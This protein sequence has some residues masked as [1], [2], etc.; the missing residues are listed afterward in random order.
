MTGPH[1]NP[2]AF[3]DDRLLAFALG[4][5]DDAELAAALD[6]APDLRERLARIADDVGRISDSL[7]ATVPPAAAGYAEPSR[8]RWP[9]LA[10]FF[11]PAD[12]TAAG[13]RRRF[14]R[15]VTPAVAAALV[16]AVVVAALIAVRPGPQGGGPNDYAAAPQSRGLSADK[17]AEQASPGGG[18][19][20]ATLGG[21]KKGSLVAGAGPWRSIL[22]ARAGAVADGVQRFAVVRKLKGDVATGVVR[23]HLTEKIRALRAG[24]LWVLYLEPRDQD[25]DGKWRDEVAATAASA[26]GLIVDGF[27]YAGRTAGVLLLDDET[28]PSTITLP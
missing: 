17:T 16:A 20:A 19:E 9:A 14:S 2:A 5:E 18:V 4:L 15:L 28:D 1:I 22:V 11:A 23:L 27:S 3:D 7:H 25:N 26:A 24:S 13:P 8:E 6:A 10:R 21:G 12:Q